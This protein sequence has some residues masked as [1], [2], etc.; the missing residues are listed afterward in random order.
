VTGCGHAHSEPTGEAEVSA[1]TGLTY[2]RYQCLDCPETFLST[3][4]GSHQWEVKANCTHP[5]W[6]LDRKEMR[7]VQGCCRYKG[8]MVK[9]DIFICPDCGQEFSIR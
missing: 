2:Y 9:T 8:K 4:G 7:P 5:N 6:Y 1:V 3:D